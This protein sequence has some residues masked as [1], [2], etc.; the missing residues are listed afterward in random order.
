M[1]TLLH[2]TTIAFVLFFVALLAE[3]WFSWRFLRG[4]KR[5][6]PGLWDAMGRRT[7]WTDGDLISAFPTISFLWSRRYESRAV[8][9]ETAYCESFRKPVVL[10]WAAAVFFV[11]LFF[12]SLLALGW[13][14]PE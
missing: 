5:H 6:Y 10:S 2:P 4:V 9:A 12:A 8:D 13:R 7:I 1:A 3:S 14:L 11:L